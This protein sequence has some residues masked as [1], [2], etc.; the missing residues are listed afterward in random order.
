MTVSIRIAAED[1][2]WTAVHRLLTDAFAY[3]DG[4]IDPPSSLHRM[5]EDDLAFILRDQG[6]RC[7]AAEV[8]FGHAMKG[9]GR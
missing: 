2:D 1:E 7:G 3:M 4:R 9:G 8:V 6:R 5:T